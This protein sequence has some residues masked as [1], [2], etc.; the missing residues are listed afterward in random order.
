LI[1]I[2]ELGRGTSTKDGFGLASAIAEF[3]AKNISCLTLF[4][5]HFHE[6]TALSEKIPIV[7]NYHVQADSNVVSK[8]LTLLYKVIPGACDQS[9]GIHVAE[10]ASFPQTVIKLAK[11]KASQL[12]DFNQPLY[13]KWKSSPAEIDSGKSIIE[14]FLRE[15]K[16]I[17]KSQ[18]DKQ[19]PL[20]L[21]KYKNEFDNPFIQEV[22]KEF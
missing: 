9:F 13:Q 8:T 6:I 7:Q 10:L 21:E 19:V 17:A 22:I 4:A 11:R 15:F 14:T 3:I 1:I 12:E 18:L 5:T 16:Q 20:L 2:D